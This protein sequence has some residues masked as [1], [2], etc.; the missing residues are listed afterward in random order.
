MQGRGKLFKKIREYE[1]S[2]LSI[3][4][5]LTKE[6]EL[7]DN[8]VLVDINLYEGLTVIDPLSWGKQSELNGEIYEY[9]DNKTYIIPVKYSIT[10]CFH[11]DGISEEE[12][13]KIRELIEEH[14]MLVLHDKKV[15]LGINAIK[16]LGL[17]I[18]GALLLSMYFVLQVTSIQQLFMEFLSIAGTFALWEAVDFYLLERREIQQERLNAGQIVLSR[19]IFS[20]KNQEEG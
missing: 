9:I 2:M 10:L 19:V 7:K 17:G 6:F 15:D 11:H 18:V 16:V 8:E 5:Y 12:Q 1:A 20:Q 3:K 13:N 14:Y 4:D